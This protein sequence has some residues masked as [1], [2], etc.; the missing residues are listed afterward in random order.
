MFSI[1]FAIASIFGQYGIKGS[2]GML[3]YLIPS[4]ICYMIV[5]F[6]LTFFAIKIS[7]KIIKLCFTKEEINI[8]EEIRKYFKILLFSFIA[9]LAIS[10]MEIFIDPL[11]IKLFTKI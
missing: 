1:G 8:K 9:M 11:L 5:L 7:Y 6:L 2:V 3:C 10:I 4:K